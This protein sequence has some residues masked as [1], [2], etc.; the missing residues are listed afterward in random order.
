VAG[1][2]ALIDVVGHDLTTRGF[3]YAF[4]EGKGTVTLADGRV[5]DLSTVAQAASTSDP[6]TW[7]GL[8]SRSLDALLT[9]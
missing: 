4:D 1:E 3:K 2:D 6:T 9:P 7:P 8:V 5:I